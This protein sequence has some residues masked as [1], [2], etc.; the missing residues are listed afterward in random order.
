MTTRAQLKRLNQ[1]NDSKSDNV[2][3]NEAII[4]PKIIEELSRKYV[5]K[6]PRVKSSL[7]DNIIVV[8]AYKNHKKIFEIEFVN[9]NVNEKFS[10]EKILL[11]LD[12]M[13]TLNKVN[14]LQWPMNDNIF[15][16]YTINEFKDECEKTLKNLKISLI[17]EVITIENDLEKRE[18]LNKYH[19]D[20]IIG[21]HMGQKKLYEKIRSHF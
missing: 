10:L 21:G 6:I 14:K 19:N 7:Y 11:S 1:T 18:I 20:P 13:A 4:E 2:T 17:S 8:G 5:R 16:V 3:Q 12:Q 15:T 9:N